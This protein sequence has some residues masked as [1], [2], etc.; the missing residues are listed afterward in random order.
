MP[1]TARYRRAGVP[2]TGGASNPVR[3]VE[4]GHEAGTVPDIHIGRVLPVR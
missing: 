1:R 3:H 4:A 2:Y